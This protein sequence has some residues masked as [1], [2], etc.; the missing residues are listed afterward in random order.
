[1]AQRKNGEPSFSAGEKNGAMMIMNDPSSRLHLAPQVRK[2]KGSIMI[3][4]D[5]TNGE[6]SCPAGEKRGGSRTVALTW[7]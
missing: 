1:M 3:I 4:N 2:E 6:P 5:L 7:G